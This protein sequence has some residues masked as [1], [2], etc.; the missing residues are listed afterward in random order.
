MKTNLA[1]YLYIYYDISPKK[2]LKIFLNFKK[3]FGEPLIS[4]ISDKK[5]KKKDLKNSTYF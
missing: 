4:T 1:K 2:D 5:T 3:N